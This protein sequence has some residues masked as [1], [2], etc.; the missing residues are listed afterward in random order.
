MSPKRTA[1]F[2]A[3]RREEILDA[4]IELF[5]TQGYDRTT[6]RAIA[7]AVGISTGGIYVYYPTKAAMLQAICTNEAARMQHLL[8]ETL[9]NLPAD[10]DPLTVT[11]MMFVERFKRLN[12]EE[13]RQREQISMLLKY[14]ARRDDEVAANLR[15]IFLS[16]RQFT[17]Q[18]LQAH[19][20]AGRIRADLNIEA[21]TELFL[22][23][24]EGFENIELFAGP[25]LDWPTIIATI[26]DTLW[27]GL[28]PEAAL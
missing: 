2:K 28:A 17:H 23:L 12:P 10:A 3:D 9:A 6:M 5:V 22:A 16:W 25:T 21:L 19:Q 15:E 14:E 27:H 18:H 20:A 26:A 4:A 7:Q 8:D 13:R 11:L 1:A 24:P